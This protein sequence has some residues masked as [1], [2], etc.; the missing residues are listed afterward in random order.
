MRVLI[1]GQV[2]HCALFGGTANGRARDLGSDC[3]GKRP[4]TGHDDRAARRE[5][6]HR[7]TRL[8]QA[9][10]GGVSKHYAAAFA[11]LASSTAAPPPSCERK[12]VLPLA[13][14]ERA[15]PLALQLQ[16]EK[17]A[18]GAH[19]QRPRLA[20]TANVQMLRSPLPM[21]PRTATERPHSR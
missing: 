8:R 6:G 7:P 15:L 19:T 18:N 4:E 5:D 9:A 11:P 21:R 13:Q 3:T 14:R 17:A 12:R 16:A 2:L 20:E 10:L 1:E